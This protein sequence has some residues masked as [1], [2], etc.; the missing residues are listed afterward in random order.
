MPPATNFGLEVGA[1][2]ALDG[3]SRTVVGVV[4]NPSDLRD[5][6][7]LLPP[8]SDAAEDGDG[9]GRRQLRAGHGVPAARG[10]NRDIGE[11]GAGNE[12][13]FAPVG[14]LG[15]ATVALV[16]IALLAAAGFVVVA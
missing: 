2:V 10:G 14:V 15:V 3:T 1:A 7:V 16:L 8:G 11:R 6:F 4:E 12:G 9:P 13:V 5:K